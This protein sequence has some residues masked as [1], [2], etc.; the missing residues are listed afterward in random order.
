MISLAFAAFLLLPAALRVAAAVTDNSSIVC[1]NSPSLCSRPYDEITYLGAHDSPFLRNADTG[2]ST[3]GN[4][5]YNSTAQL[6]A[7]VRLLTAQVQLGG[8]N[9]DE[10]HVCHTSCD[11]LDA[12]TL[13]E[14]LGEVRRW[15]DSNPND[16]VTLLLVNGAGADASSLAQHYQTAGMTD[17][18][19]TPQGSGGAT[20][21]WPNLQTLISQRTRIM[22]FVADLNDNSAAPYLMNQFDYVFENN[23]DISS[24]SDFSCDINR[25]APLIGRTS[26]AISN[27]YLPL[28]NHFLYQSDGGSFI[29]IEQP[30]ATYVTTTNAPSGGLGNLGIAADTCKLYYGRAP[31]FIL[32]DFFNVGPAI[33]T[34]DR[35]NGVSTPVGRAKVSTAN[36][37]PE[38]SAAALLAGGSWK[39]MGLGALMLLGSTIV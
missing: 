19:Y 28:M 13:A 25:P 10:L 2:Y 15:V 11:L 8:D 37:A 24:P 29:S 4:Q 5:Y 16:V 26:Q 27:G 20:Q 23:Y 1:N 7:G 18:S 17:L 36:K 14:W 38:E 30:N 9:E 34:V 3:S 12:G 33:A 21:S 39:L 6:G 22:N 32:V 31:S 35:L